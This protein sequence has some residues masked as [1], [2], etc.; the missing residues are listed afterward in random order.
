M[1]CENCGQEIRIGMWPWCPHG[2]GI[3]GFDPWKP[4]YDDH[5]A[6]PPLPGEKDGF[7]PLRAPNYVPG[8]G[9]EIRHRE[10]R[11]RLMRINHM[12]ERG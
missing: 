7:N 1:T 2:T 6:P 4:Y 3:G 9:W 8:K 5:V 12:K 10:D 11:T